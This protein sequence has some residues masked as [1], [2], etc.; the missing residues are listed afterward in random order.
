MTSQHEKDVLLDQA[1]ENQIAADALDAETASLLQLASAV[2][3]SLGETPPPPHGLR[4]GRSAFLTAALHQP[5]K[6]RGLVQIPGLSRL[7]GWVLPLAAVAIMAILLGT[8]FVNA[9]LLPPSFTAKLMPAMHSSTATPTDATTHTPEIKAT[10]TMAPEETIPVEPY[11]PEQQAFPTPQGSPTLVIMPP[12]VQPAH[13]TPMPTYPTPM[14]PS[15]TAMPAITVTTTITPGAWGTPRPWFTGTISAGDV[16]P[17]IIPIIPR[18]TIT[19]GLVTSPSLTITPP[20][21][22]PVSPPQTPF[23]DFWQG[24]RRRFPG[25]H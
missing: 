19:P 8:V 22:P 4:P 9:D 20:A 10:D 25:R 12:T 24:I 17:I 5:Q 18:L 11:S 2:Q 3:A 21:L 15:L 13:P 1:F 6:R 7:M 14:P 16:T 23:R